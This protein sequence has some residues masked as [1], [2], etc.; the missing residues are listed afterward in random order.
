MSTKKLFS[1]L[2]PQKSLHGDPTIVPNSGLQQLCNVHSGK[3]S[4]PPF[5]SFL[6][7]CICVAGQCLQEGDAADAA[8]TVRTDIY[9]TS[10]SPSHPRYSTV[11]QS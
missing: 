11:I 2:F 4:H 1:P 6:N 9:A 5:V 3:L 10:A 8:Q 7:V